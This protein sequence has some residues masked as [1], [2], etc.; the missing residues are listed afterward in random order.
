[1]SDAIPTCRTCGHVVFAHLPATL[2]G[3]GCEECPCMTF[4]SDG[5]PEPVRDPGQRVVDAVFKDRSVDDEWSVRAF[6]PGRSCCA[7]ASTSTRISPGARPVRGRH[8]RQRATIRT[9]CRRRRASSPTGSTADEL[10]RAV[11]RRVTG[12]PDDSKR[13]RAVR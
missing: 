10:S 9:S 13:A 2:G 11:G 1:M 4:V 6:R 8:G 12:S 5:A 3:N 7:C